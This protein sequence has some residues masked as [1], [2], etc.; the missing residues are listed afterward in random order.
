MLDKRCARPLSTHP[1]KSWEQLFSIRAIIIKYERAHNL[2][3][4]LGD[5]LA[6]WSRRL[7]HWATQSPKIMRERSILSY[8][9]GQDLNLQPF[10]FQ[11]NALSNYA[12]Q[13]LDFVICIVKQVDI[14]YNLLF[15][16]SKRNNKN[17]IVA[18]KHTIA[19]SK[20]LC[21]Y[22]CCTD[23]FTIVVCHVSSC[24]CRS[25]VKC[26]QMGYILGAVDNFMVST[27]HQYGIQHMQSSSQ[28]F[29]DV[30]IESVDD[31]LSIF[32]ASTNFTRGSSH[33]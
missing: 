30:V 14:I 1:S 8:S 29:L 28:H 6:S 32:D 26:S 11:L 21:S 15:N 24:I 22:I 31:T 2:T 17:C 16:Q 18:G 20:S 5:P 23:S 10:D 25:K 13:Q 12:T 7:N 19:A 4:N 27:Q 3:Q 33:F 9:L